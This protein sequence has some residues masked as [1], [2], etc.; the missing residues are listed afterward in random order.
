MVNTAGQA[1]F[2]IDATINFDPTKLEVVSVAPVSGNGFNSYPS[3]KF[4]NSKGEVAISGNI[5]TGNAAHHQLFLNAATMHSK[6][7]LH[8]TATD[9]CLHTR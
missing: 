7:L 4:N 5:G 8:H 9:L 6:S 2:G 3:T 1:I